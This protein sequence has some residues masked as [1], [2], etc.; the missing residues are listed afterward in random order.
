M[1]LQIEVKVREVSRKVINL[2]LSRNRFLSWSEFEIVESKHYKIA[3]DK[4]ENEN[5]SNDYS[6]KNLNGGGF[7]KIIMLVFHPRPRMRTVEN[8]WRKGKEE[9]LI[10]SIDDKMFEWLKLKHNHL[11]D[12]EIPP[13]PYRII[14]DE[15]FIFD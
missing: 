2:K 3:E 10:T 11:K 12:H 7:R 15:E 4:K 6:C 14:F 5:G 9:W 1:S 8:M 13:R